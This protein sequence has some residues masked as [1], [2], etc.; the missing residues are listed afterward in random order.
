MPSSVIEPESAS[1]SVAMRAHQRRLAGAVRPEQAE[2]AG[3]DRERDVAQ[4]LD[5]VR[6]GLGQV[7]NLELQSHRFSMVWLLCQTFTSAPAAGFRGGF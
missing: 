6:V 5:A 7:S 2:H 4:R 1:C 3:A